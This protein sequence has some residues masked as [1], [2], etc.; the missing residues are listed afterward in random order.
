MSKS[1]KKIR[2]KDRNGQDTS[3]NQEKPNNP[4][5]KN[6]TDDIRLIDSQTVEVNPVRS[7]EKSSLFHW[8][9]SEPDYYW[10]GELTPCDEFLFYIGFYYE[11]KK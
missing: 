7:A 9:C 3:P 8:L 11:P 1:R 4:H 5:K 6:R 2:S 10:I